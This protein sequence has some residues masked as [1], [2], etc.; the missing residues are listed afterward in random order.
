MGEQEEVHKISVQFNQEKIVQDNMSNKRRRAPSISRDL[1][2]LVGEGAMTKTQAQ[3]IMEERSSSESSSKRNHRNRRKKSSSSISSDLLTLVAEGS[4]TQIQASNLMTEREHPTLATKT[5]KTTK[6]A[7][8]H[9]KKSNAVSSTINT[10]PTAACDRIQTAWQPQKLNIIDCRSTNATQ[11]VDQTRTNGVPVVITGFPEMTQFAQRWVDRKQQPDFEQLSRDLGNEIVTCISKSNMS[12]VSEK[13]GLAVK[14]KRSSGGGS[15]GSSSGSSSS[16]SVGDFQR[17]KLKQFI[18]RVF[19]NHISH[20]F[21]VSEEDDDDDPF[22][23]EEGVQTG[24]GGQPIAQPGKGG[25]GCRAAKGTKKQTSSS[26]SKSTTTTTA[27]TTNDN[28]NDNDR[29]LYLHQW[30]FG[31]SASARRVIGDFEGHDGGKR[32]PVPNCLHTDLLKGIFS[33]FGGS[34][35]YQYLFCGPANTWTGMHSDPGGLA[36]LIAP[37]TGIKEV[38]LVHREDYHL[39]GNSWRDEQSLIRGYPDLNMAPMAQFARTWRHR[40]YPGDVCLLPAGTFHAVRNITTCLSYHRMHMDRINVP[41]LY[42][43]FVN[44]DTTA[45]HGIPHRRMLWNAAHGAIE[46]LEHSSLEKIL[47]VEAL[48]DTLVLHQVVAGMRIMDGRSSSYE[49]NELLNDL[50]TFYEDTVTRLER[51][52]LQVLLFFILARN[53]VG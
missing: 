14:R 52:C 45:T 24:K 9:T 50:S 8:T 32:I 43:S 41:R 34:N 28:D 21:Y 6:K 22:S 25:K 16:S 4:M 20:D 2:S 15:S 49:W 26:T 46:T 29:T 19:P 47:K 13:G 53:C 7:T 40:L 38:V 33:E 39:V 18:R 42:S 51:P 17:M 10:L 30:Q 44:G 35:P 27:A 11:V 48:E 12:K 3:K 31:M 37:I 5:T 36:I 1:A 23:D